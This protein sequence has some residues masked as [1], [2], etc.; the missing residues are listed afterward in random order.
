MGSSVSTRTSF[1]V[2]GPGAGSKYAKAIKL[3]V[4]VIAAEHFAALLSDGPAGLS[5]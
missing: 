2:A 1:L 3:G 4:P 5:E